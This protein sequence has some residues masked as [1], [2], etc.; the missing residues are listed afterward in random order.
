MNIFDN[1]DLKL[2][3]LLETFNKFDKFQLKICL[4][5]NCTKLNI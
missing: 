2:Q 1:F 3:K 4:N 5:L